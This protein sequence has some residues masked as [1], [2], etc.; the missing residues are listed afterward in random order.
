M[1]IETIII[2][3]SLTDLLRIAQAL[4]H[5]SSVTDELQF[6]T[7]TYQNP[8]DMNRYDKEWYIIDIDLGDISGFDIANEIKVKNPKAY[9]IFCTS[10]DDLV[11]QSFD[12]DVFY[13]IRKDH[14]E[15]DLLSAVRKYIRMQ[16]PL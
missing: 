1:R 13:F 16:I 11:F 2:D 10:H 9:I 6:Q 14:L 5:L 12:V 8:N 4:N 15:Q 3:D 7:F